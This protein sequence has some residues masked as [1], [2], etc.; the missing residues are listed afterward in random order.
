MMPFSPK[1]RSGATSSQATNPKSRQ[2]H[3]NRPNVQNLSE[4]HTKK[5]MSLQQTKDSLLLF[6]LS[7]L[8]T[9]WA[10]IRFRPLFPRPLLLTFHLPKPTQTRKQEAALKAAKGPLPKRPRKSEVTYVS[11]WM[12]TSL[13]M[14][15]ANHP[16]ANLPRVLRAI[17]PSLARPLVPV[18]P[19][20][21][22]N[23]SNGVPRRVRLKL[24]KRKSHP[25]K[26]K[27]VQRKRLCRRHLRRRHR[28]RHLASPREVGNVSRRK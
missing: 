8:P 1:N 11:I 14:T 13:L 22:K 20:L 25:K 23:S 15:T 12:L 7:L 28:E 18:R 3:Q 10:S 16:R 5:T 26:L 2:N 21:R 6:F 9:A 24:R 27:K 19:S 17:A 4:T